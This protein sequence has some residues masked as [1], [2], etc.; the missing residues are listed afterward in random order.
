MLSIQEY[1]QSKSVKGLVQKIFESRQVIHVLHLKTKSYSEHVAL[2]EY[3]E[4]II[5]FAD[6]FV[7]TYQGQYGILN[8]YEISTQQSPSDSVKYLEDCVT[9]FKVGRD[10]LKDAHLQNLMDEIISLTYKTLYKLKFLK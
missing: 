4:K 5:D 9:L 10:F 7:E 1:N 8:D 6:D 3:Y 2:K